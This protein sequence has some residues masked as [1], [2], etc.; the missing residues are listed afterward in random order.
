MTEHPKFK[1]YF[2]S[3]EGIAFKKKGE[4]FVPMIGTKCGNGYRAITYSVNGVYQKR[5][6]IHRE[7]C[8]LFNGGDGVGLHCRHLDGDINNNAASNLAWGT[9]LE[10]AQDKKRHGTTA[11]GEK[12]P[13][14]VLTVEKVREMRRIRE[15][16]GKPYYAIASDFGVSTMTAF[17]AVTQRA[18][19]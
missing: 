13:M 4:K 1:G 17:R 7:I 14:A 2:F 10:N 5:E 11:T 12:N 8:R 18:W 9:A 6:Y 15:A 19:L 16:T 3:K